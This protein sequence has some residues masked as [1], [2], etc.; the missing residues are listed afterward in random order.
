M[1]LKQ[2]CVYCGSNGGR[3]PEYLEQARAFGQE[4]VKR[5]IGL[6]YGGAAVGLMGAVA[7]G[8]MQAGGRAVGIIPVSLMQKE[9]A[10][11]GLTELHVVQSMHE[12]KTMMAEQADGFVALPGGAGTLE[13]IFETWTWAQLGMHRKPCGLLNIA[14]YYDDLARFLD[15]TVAEAFMRPQHRAMLAIESDAAALLDRFAAYEP[16]TVSKWIIQGEH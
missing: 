1:P 13:E 11:R 12:R 15:H 14:G 10:H 7:D 3:Q 5:D 9:L 2:I 8:V 6:V 4:L 16:P